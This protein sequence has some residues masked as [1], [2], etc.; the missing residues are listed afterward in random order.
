MFFVFFPSEI[1]NG[2]G[3]SCELMTYPAIAVVSVLGGFK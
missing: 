1:L 2:V 3:K